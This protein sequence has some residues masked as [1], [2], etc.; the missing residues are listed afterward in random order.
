MTIDKEVKELVEGWANE[1]L[2]YFGDEGGF[3]KDIQELLN[4]YKPKSEPT[5]NN[6]HNN[7]QPLTM[8][9]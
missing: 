2:I 3:E 9:E 1:G 6:K 7:F 8:I 5:F 4:K